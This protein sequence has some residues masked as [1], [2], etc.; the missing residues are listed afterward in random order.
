MRVAFLILGSFLQVFGVALSGLQIHRIR[1]AFTSP[2]GTATPGPFTVAWSGVRSTTSGFGRLASGLL[3]WLKRKVAWEGLGAHPRQLPLAG[4][5]SGASLGN[6]TPSTAVTPGCFQGSLPQSTEDALSV[7]AERTTYLRDHLDRTSAELR[8]EIKREAD[9]RAVS[10]NDLES[11]VSRVREDLASYAVGQLNLGIWGV[12]LIC[13]GIVF[14][15][16]A[17][18]T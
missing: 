4:F 1:A 10:I 15:S 17:S 18:L 6:V 9:S 2:S 7:L 11:A 16:V 12:V 8:G 13:A 14:V 5:G 3:K